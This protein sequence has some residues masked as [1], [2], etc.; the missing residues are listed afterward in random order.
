MKVCLWY[1]HYCVGTII[2]YPDL[3]DKW[4]KENVICSP[5][6]VF[7]S[8]EQLIVRILH[9]GYL[10]YLKDRNS[11]TNKGQ[12]SI[13]SL[14]KCCKAEFPEVEQAVRSST[15]IPIDKLVK[16]LNYVDLLSP[17][18]SSEKV[19]YF[20]P[21]ILERAPREELSNPP[22]SDEYHPEPLFITFKRGFVPTGTFCGLITR[23]VSLSNNKLFGIE[24]NLKQD[25]VK[26]N[27]VSFYIHN[28]NEVSFLSHEKCFEL[29]LT[30][31]EEQGGLGLHELCTQVL[32]VVLYVLENQ[33]ENI[34][35]IIAFQCRCPE[36]SSS[37]K[38]HYQHLCILNRSAVCVQ[39]LCG[40]HTASLSSN[41]KVWIGKVISRICCSLPEC[42]SKSLCYVIIIG[43]C[44]MFMD[45]I[46]ITAV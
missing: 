28:V 21:A 5:Q 29:R 33:Y 8:I 23:L 30:Y 24:W 13:D 18:E 20:M 3:P 32:S 26:Q 41:Q 12:F 6:V 19:T 36:Y 38:A 1:L 27:R 4:F 43:T 9:S 44:V 14:W 16:L 46:C 7:N 31:G 25:G 39:Y 35:P 11:W 42:L 45:A 15:L 17:I 2:Y 34:S 22:P 37:E 40:N 10:P